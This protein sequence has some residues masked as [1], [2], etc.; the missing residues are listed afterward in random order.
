MSCGLDRPNGDQSI[1]DQGDNYRISLRHIPKAH[2]GR[3]K[4]LVVED[5]TVDQLAFIRLAEQ[6]GLPY[7]YTIAES[8]TEVRAAALVVSVPN[9]LSKPVNFDQLIAMI[10]RLERSWNPHATDETPPSD[11]IGRV[12]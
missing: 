3:H 5:D 7:D 12:A 11:L 8:M 9:Y 2:T 1:I 6:D 4:V 10:A